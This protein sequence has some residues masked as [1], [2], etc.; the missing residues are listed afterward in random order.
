[1]STVLS[2][3]LAV[4][5]A[6]VAA[7]LVRRKDQSRDAAPTECSRLVT[8]AFVNANDTPDSVVMGR[9]IPHRDRCLGDAG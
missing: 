7:W 5:V 8:D 9:L 4:A 6:G 3:L 2:I 1:M